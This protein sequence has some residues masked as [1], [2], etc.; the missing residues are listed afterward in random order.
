MTGMG[1]SVLVVERGIARRICVARTRRPL[2]D[3]KLQ[4]SDVSASQHEKIINSTASST[5]ISDSAKPGI[6]LR[7]VEA[8]DGRNDFFVMSLHEA[9]STMKKREKSV[10]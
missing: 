3:A 7:G 4:T 6:D 1:K 5:L 9:A 10:S 2:R 8:L